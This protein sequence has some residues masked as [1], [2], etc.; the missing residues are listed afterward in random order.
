MTYFGPYHGGS[1]GNFYKVFFIFCSGLGLGLVLFSGQNSNSS[2]EGIKNLY[3]QEYQNEMTYENKKQRPSFSLKDSLDLPTSTKNKQAKKQAHTKTQESSY[4]NKHGVYTSRNVKDQ[5]PTA[6]PGFQNAQTDVPAMGDD[7]EEDD[8]LS[9]EKLI[10][11]SKSD[12]ALQEEL[13]A[14]QREIEDLKNQRNEQKKSTGSA[15]FASVGMYTHYD[16]NDLNDEDENSG[17]VAIIGGGGKRPGD[18]IDIEDLELLKEFSLDGADLANRLLSSNSLSMPEYIDYMAMGLSSSNSSL[19]RTAIT[20]LSNKL[21]PEAF[22]TLAQFSTTASASNNEFLDSQLLQQ[23]STVQGLRF[24]SQQ[25]SNSDALL[26][27]QLAVNTVAV[28]LEGDGN[29][30]SALFDVLMTNVLS[31]LNNLPSDHPSFNRGRQLSA[32]IPTIVNS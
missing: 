12:M 27:S 28:I 14:R 6:P 17:G 20:N 7:E 32:L 10:D 23:M 1:V 25:I 29:L 2:G 11:Y 4:Y 9:E 13:E 21:D 5:I 22:Y 15:N 8:G 26:S 24:L 30:S 18:D 16:E 3:E 19:Q 31:S